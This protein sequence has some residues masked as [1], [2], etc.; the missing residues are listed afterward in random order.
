MIEAINAV[1]S[2]ATSWV[3]SLLSGDFGEIVVTILAVTLLW[4]LVGLV[5]GALK[6]G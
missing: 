6:R 1:W 3:T 4:V 5:Y 2:G